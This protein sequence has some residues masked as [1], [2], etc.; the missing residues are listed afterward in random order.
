MK[1][2]IKGKHRKKGIKKKI[3]DIN[4]Q[5]Y[6][7]ESYYFYILIEA[8]IKSTRKNSKVKLNEINKHV[9]NIYSE[10]IHDLWEK[11]KLNLYYFDF[12][13]IINSIFS[14]FII[15]TLVSFA[16]SNNGIE[17]STK[18]YVCLKNVF[19]ENFW[20]SYFIFLI[21][22]IISTIILILILMKIRQ[23]DKTQGIAYVDY[24]MQKNRLNL[25]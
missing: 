25:K 3:M 2:F 1:I 17:I 20:K 13:V 19:Q 15:S 23:K 16:F 11:K 18:L 6:I 9:N 8:V 10:E 4:S 24:L 5:D 12:S 14:S 7:N 22:L 21:I